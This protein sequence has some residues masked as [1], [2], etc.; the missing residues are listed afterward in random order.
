MQLRMCAYVK[1]TVR[2]KNYFHKY[3]VFCS[4][5]AQIF[6]NSL[7]VNRRDDFQDLL[8]LARID[9]IYTYEQNGTIYDCM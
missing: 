2:D 9:N 5:L 1:N 6:T 4:I 8:R 7:A 3:V